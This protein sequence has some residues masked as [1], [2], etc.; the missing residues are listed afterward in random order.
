MTDEMDAIRSIRFGL[1]RAA[2]EDARGKLLAYLR[3]LG[4]DFPSTNDGREHY[5]AT[6]KLIMALIER[7]DEDDVFGA[8]IE[9][10]DG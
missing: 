10:K 9:G 8:A 3:I 5:D 2:W 6:Q 1:E 4:S 7:I